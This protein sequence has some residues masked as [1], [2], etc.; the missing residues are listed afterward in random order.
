VVAVANKV[1]PRKNW[2]LLI[3]PSVSLATA[4]RLRFAGAVNVAA[5]I[6]LAMLTIGA[7]LA[8]EL[9]K[10]VTALDVVTAPR[11]SVALAAIV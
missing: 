11:L 10:M 3:V 1:E 6:G 9:T 8:G 2:T 5:L 7:T 4:A